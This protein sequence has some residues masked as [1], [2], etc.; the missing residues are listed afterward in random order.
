MF[1][2]INGRLFFMLHLYQQI[3]PVLKFSCF[4][5]SITCIKRNNPSITNMFELHEKGNFVDM[6]NG[7]K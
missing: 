2:M 4:Y 1:Q 6:V 3:R 7:Q 5:D